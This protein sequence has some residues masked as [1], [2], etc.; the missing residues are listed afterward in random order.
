MT[1]PT[2]ATRTAGRW[3]LCLLADAASIHTERW[4]RYFA[5]QGHEVHVFSLRPAV[6][7]GVF[8]H[9]LLPLWPGKSGYPTVVL[10]LREMLRHLQPDLVHAHYLTSYGL[11]GVLAG[12]RPLVVSMWGSDVLDFPFK[13]PLHR[14]LVAWI[15]ARA[16]MLMSTSEAMVRTVRPWL[17]SDRTVH[18]TPFGVDVDAFHPA[19]EEPEGPVVIG[20]SCYLIPRKRID[21]LLRSAATLIR[22]PSGPEIRVRIAGEGAERARLEALAAELGIADRVTWLGWLNGEDLAAAI[23]E[24]SLMVVPS[25]QEAFGVVALEAAASGVPIVATRVDGFVE[26]VAEGISGLLVPPDDEEALTAALASLVDD[27]ERRRAMGRSARDWVC[28]TYAWN[29]TAERMAG[30]YAQ[31]IRQ[32]E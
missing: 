13:S 15:M 17:P 18:V 2:T 6:I 9:H 20:T 11:L 4:A 3:R 21:L 24:F 30:L 8:V 1:D 26:S 32:P 14:R 16:D 25:R 10:R 22:R 27:G 12:V 29:L 28:R 7:P 5:G 19:G 31:V 23:R